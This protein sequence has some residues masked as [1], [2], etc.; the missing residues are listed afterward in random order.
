MSQ[1]TTEGGQLDLLAATP[2]RYTEAWDYSR[3]PRLAQDGMIVESQTGAR[4]LVTRHQSNWSIAAIGGNMRI[5]TG[6]FA[7]ISTAMKLFEERGKL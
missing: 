7:E 2:G 6:T 3:T 4:A 5:E 1:L